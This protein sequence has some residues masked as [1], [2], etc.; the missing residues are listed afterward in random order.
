MRIEP[1]DLTEARAAYKKQPVRPRAYYEAA[2]KNRITEGWITSI[3]SNNQDVGADQETLV[4]LSRTLAQNDPTMTKFLAAVWKNVFGPDG[5]RIQSRVMMKRGGRMRPEEAPKPKPDKET[6]RVIEAAWKEW[7]KKQNCSL[8]RKLSWVQLQRVVS[9]TVAVD[10]E[11]F[12]RKVRT[13]KN[14]F[15]FA[16]QIINADR[17]DRTYGRT[18]PLILPDGNQ[19]FMGI[20][21]D[22]DG[23]VVAYH[24]FN[25]HPSE[26]GSG[27]KQRVRI[28]AEDMIHIFLPISD[29]QTR[30]IPWA[31]PAM[32]RMGILS[33]YI[34][35]ELI[36]SQVGASQMGA[37]TTPVDPNEGADPNAEAPD[38]NGAQPLDVQPGSFVHLDPGQELQMFN[39]NHPVSAFGTFVRE[40]KLD[41]AAGL[42]VAY[43]TLTG[44][45]ASANYSSARVGL[46]DE[47]DTWEG[48]QG[49]YVEE[50][51]ASVFA[52][53]MQTAFIAYPPF[54][55]WLNGIDWKVYDQAEWHPRSFP[56]VDPEKDTNAEKTKVQEG[57]TTRHR[58]LAAQGWDF[59]ETMEELAEEQKRIKELG[60]ELGEP[61]QE[62][63]AAPK[64]K[65]KEVDEKDDETK[66]KP[67]PEQ[68]VLTDLVMSAHKGK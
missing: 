1:L 53:W 38:Y 67:K 39:P 11:C 37:I 59:D 5:I 33:D 54:R 2:R 17:V 18:N 52:G 24:V 49:F 3:R 55:V 41:I 25:R 48:L 34:K 61:K 58:I 44:D 28:P 8:D 60:L 12:I 10:G 26:A 57:F 9:R 45:V 36:A 15:G 43:M 16:L 51:C 31:A 6:N 50:L 23:A 7:G 68:R 22:E 14:P 20:E 56:W 4:G 46:L 47:R 40:A 63:A 66:P 42:D 65:P 29:N 19:V 27:Q 21:M 30:G 64:D 32:M 13:D 35:A 62:A